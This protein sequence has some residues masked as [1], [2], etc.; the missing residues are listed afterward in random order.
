MITKIIMESNP[1]I[2]REAIAVLS[3]AGRGAKRK[4]SLMRKHSA[5]VCG[6]LRASAVK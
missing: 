1:Y 3:S 4:T 6:Y 2:Y 5:G